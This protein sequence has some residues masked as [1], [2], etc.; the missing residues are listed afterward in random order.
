[1]LRHGYA[2]LGT[3]VLCIVLVSC[4]MVREARGGEAQTSSWQV[5]LSSGARTTN[6]PTFDAPVGDKS[7]AGYPRLISEDFSL[8]MLGGGGRAIYTSHAGWEIELGGQYWSGSDKVSAR[9]VF[10][11]F[12]E[13]GLAVTGV[14]GASGILTATSELRGNS[15]YASVDASLLETR[16]RIARRIETG[17]LQFRPFAGLIYE[18]SDQDYEASFRLQEPAVNNLE[19]PYKLSQQVDSFRLGG[20]IGLQSII[21][22]GQSWRLHAGVAYALYHQ[23]TSM[24]AN[25]CVASATASPGFDCEDATAFHYVRLLDS[26]A[27][28]E[29]ARIASRVKL[30]AGLSYLLSFGVLAVNAFAQYD[31]AV[32]GVKNPLLT[33]DQFLG[34]DPTRPPP[35][36]LTFEDAWSYGA[37]VSLTVPLQ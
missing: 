25:D 24:T 30:E 7:V 34:A 27:K 35:A 26:S 23:R 31:T 17:T 6:L 37:T 15:V 13:Y 1:M 14:D 4:S 33:Q 16:L 20:E 10:D 5:S 21:P 29:E 8:N 36:H 2:G 9:P 22:F 32:P 28:D 3:G 19:I 11:K 18:R 12:N